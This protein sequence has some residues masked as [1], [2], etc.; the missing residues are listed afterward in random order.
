[1]KNKHKD[2]DVGNAKSRIDK[3]IEELVISLRQQNKLL[4]EYYK[5]F[6]KHQSRTTEKEWA[7]VKN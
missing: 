1:M 3:S 4:T 5:K 6:E 2:H 7:S